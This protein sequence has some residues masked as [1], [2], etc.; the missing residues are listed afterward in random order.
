MHE[1]FSKFPRKKNRTSVRF[2]SLK[3]VQQRLMLRIVLALAGGLVHWLTRRRLAVVSRYYRLC[4]M[5]RMCQQIAL[6]GQ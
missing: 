4:R 3:A 1:G 5:D 6:F 2:F